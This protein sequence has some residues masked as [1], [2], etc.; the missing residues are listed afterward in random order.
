MVVVQV[1]DI[2][3]LCKSINY[4][5][6]VQLMIPPPTIVAVFACFYDSPKVNYLACGAL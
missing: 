3:L 1:R 4:P 5:P 6:N 2:A